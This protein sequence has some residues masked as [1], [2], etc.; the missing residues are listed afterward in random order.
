MRLFILLLLSYT[1]G[2]AQTLSIS[3]Q[4]LLNTYNQRP[5]AKMSVDRRMSQLAKISTDEARKI[6]RSECKGEEP[7]LKLMNKGAYLFY[8]ASSNSCKLY[9]NALDGSLLSR[10]TLYD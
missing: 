3:D 5:S 2:F 4:Q 9:I 1:F 10:E 6:A 7:K 8:Y